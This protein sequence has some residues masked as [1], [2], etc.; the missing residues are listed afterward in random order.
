MHHMEMEATTAWCPAVIRLAY[1]P[2]HLS[3]PD[4]VLQEL[5]AAYAAQLSGKGQH[6]QAAAQLAAA[7]QWAA[8]AAALCARRTAAGSAVAVHM[9]RLA[10]SRRPTGMSAEEESKVQEQLAAAEQLLSARA[11]AEGTDAAAVLAAAL[12]PP[13]A[14]Q[15]QEPA[16]AGGDAA[17]P[18]AGGRAQRQRYSPAQ[19]M[20]VPAAQGAPRGLPQDL[21]A[22]GPPQSSAGLAAAPALAGDAAVFGRSGASRTRYSL[23]ALLEV[24]EAAQAAGGAGLRG[25]LPPELVQPLVE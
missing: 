4:H 14:P 13:A 12:P 15:Q 8:A 7:G 3:P 1:I 2:A 11:E 20:A 5:R 21:A 16:A 17:A 9:C 25:Q 24:S 19:L 6:E 18:A 22:G 10:L 23:Q